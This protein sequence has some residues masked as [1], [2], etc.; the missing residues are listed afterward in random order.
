MRRRS[1]VI[2]PLMLITIGAL[3]LLGNVRPDL[4]AW[5]VA[6]EYW[7]FLLIAWGALRLLE[8]ALWALR[9]R[10]LPV[11]GV[12]GGEWTLVV[13]LCVFGSGLYLAHNRF[14]PPWA[15]FGLRGVEWFG[16][17]YDYPL[18]VKRVQAGRSPRVIVENF[19][20]N[21]RITGI[22]STEVEV[23]GRKTV[24]AIRESDAIG[25]DRET[26]LEIVQ[27]G[28]SILVR[29]NQERRRRGEHVTADL[30]IAV[31]KGASIEA[32]GRVGDFDITDLDGNIEIVSDNAGVRVQNVGG[33]VRV[34]LRKSDLIR[35]VN[36]KGSVELK[37]RG[38]NIELDTIAGQVV[39]SGVYVGDID[40]RGV[41]KPIRYDGAQTDFSV[42]SC[43][44]QIRM[45]RGY[46]NAENIVGP[47]VLNAKSKDVQIAGFTQSVSLNLERGDIELRPGKLPLGRMDV[48]TRSGHIEFAVPDGAKFE[49]K[50]NVHRGEVQNDFGSPLMVSSEGRGG[51]ILGVIGDG[52]QI[53]LSTDRGSVTVRKASGADILT[54]MPPRPPLPPRDKAGN[55]EDI[56]D[57][58]AEAI[59]RR[60][61]ELARRLEAGADRLHRKIEKEID[62]TTTKIQ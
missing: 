11:S 49:M 18:E 33:A 32:R 4:S 5:E 7:P 24:R 1:S 50:A 52:P 34:D 46:L 31:P 54:P 28:D 44:G 13:L 36:V 51:T 9:R 35:A 37:G 30:D 45:A 55:V 53:V 14:G 21:T 17:P 60:A 61:D 48:V 59:E 29:T 23:K 27:N 2:G 3:F 20:G 39:I 25:A 38:D 62:R 22:D 19:H 6:A 12:S 16:E 26:P 42:E 47:L 40:I 58:H 43:P 8:L 15:R 10:P 57:R 41:A 56:V